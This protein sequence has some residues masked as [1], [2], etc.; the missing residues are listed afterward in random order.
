[1]KRSVVSLSGPT[2]R[3]REMRALF[4]EQRRR[5]RSLLELS[6]QHGI[7][8]GT[9]AWWKYV[10][11]QREAARSGSVVE[12]AAFVPVRVMAS[13]EDE[14]PE[15]ERGGGD[16]FEVLL[17]GGRAIRVPAHFDAEG[18]RRL[19]ATLEEVGC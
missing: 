17:R 15:G 18:L 5:G 16:A 13:T 4:T 6:R 9:L 12:R 3:E 14:R 8:L 7:P 2:V 10:I 11:R 19:V 1:M